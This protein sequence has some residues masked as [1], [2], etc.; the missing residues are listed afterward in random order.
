MGPRRATTVLAWSLF[1]LWAA[2]AVATP[3]LGSG[4]PDNGDWYFP[5][6]A[7]GYATAGALVA[8]RHP[9]NAVGWLLL[10]IA[11]TVGLQFIG[12][13][14]VLS[15]F[16]GYVAVAWVVGWSFNAWAL[17]VAVFLP[18]I[19]PT[20]RLLSPRWRVAWW[21]AV[22]SLV[23]GIVVVGL[24]PGN[25]ALEGPVQNPLG[26]HGTARTVVEAAT[27]W[28]VAA[29]ALCVLL[30]AVSVILRFGRSTGVER[31]QLKWFASVTLTALG[32]L[33]VSAL[34]DVVPTQLGVLLNGL[35]WVVFLFGCI[36]GIPIATGI[37]ILRYRLYDVDLVINRTLVYGSLTAA[38]VATYVVS[39]LL[40][41]VVLSPI[42]GQSDLA[43]AGSTLVVAA[44][45]RPARAWIQE[46]VDR[47]FYRRRYDAVHTLEDFSTRL[48]HELDLDAVGTDL[49]TT[50]DRA[51]QPAHV[52]LWLRGVHR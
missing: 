6:L 22:V 52:S 9:G 12:Q 23:A 10:V 2:T 24:T 49:C 25:L 51:V 32:G 17:L 11:L 39:I 30:S 50:A 27:G 18:L 36:L 20:G 37:A 35:G 44:V 19:F 28:I 15:H 26:V 48:R 40:L 8:S 3:W 14:Y 29:T 45:F 7:V 46:L 33:G 43:V 4:Q 21:F 47:R 34:G 42:T 1:A 13:T 16:S 5:L 41:R 31:Q 38:S